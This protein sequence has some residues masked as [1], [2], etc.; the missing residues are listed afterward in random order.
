MDKVTERKE[1]FALMPKDHICR[2]L[3]MFA[4]KSNVIFAHCLQGKHLRQITKF[5]YPLHIL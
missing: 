2:T 5:T 1:G 4:A 3:L